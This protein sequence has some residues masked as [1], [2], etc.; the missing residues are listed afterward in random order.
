MKNKLNLSLLAILVAGATAISSCKKSSNSVD[1]PTISDSNESLADA[2]F[3][4]VSYRGAFGSTDWTAT[5]ANYTPN[6][7]QYGA[8]TDV[9]TGTISTN[10]TL[11]ANKIYLLS[12]FVY[13][14]EGVTLTIPAGT[15]I[16]GDKISKG[17]LVVTR[18][19]KLIAQGTIDKPIVF[20]SNFAPGQRNPGDW[21]GVILLGKSTNNIPGGVGVIE[22]GISTPEANHGG[23]DPL[24]NSG[25]LKFVRIEFPGIAF[26]KDNEINGLTLGSV[27]SGTTIDYVQVSY[28]GD[29]SFE[30]FGG[31]VNAK[32]LLSIANV[33]DVFDFDN[34]FSGKLQFLA[35][36]RDPKLAD[37]AGQSNGI[38]SDNSAGD[39]TAGPRT[40]PVI[41][42]MTIIG[43]GNDNVDTKHEYANLWRRGSKMILA[44]SIFI[45][46]RYGIDIRDKETGDALVDGTSLIKGN[47]YQ[48]YFVGKDIVADGTIP[49]F[50]NVDLLKTYLTSKNNSTVDATAAAALLANPFNLNAPS[51]VLKSGSVASSGA[52]F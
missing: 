3:D 50:A 17:T 8:T 38:E 5:W 41:S 47:I 51:L 20:T 22:G 4:K 36:L 30:W 21:G 1:V 44:N 33:D 45:G 14:K 48:S 9:L 7:T 15:V 10:T 2:F 23:T 43:P 34:G 24:D 32:H 28:S 13:V 35:G 49:S 39:F 27:G 31:T 19:A 29:D 16:R 46:S 26:V 52:T 42:N 18:G 37:Q 12:G 40:R 11:D 25:I 6:A